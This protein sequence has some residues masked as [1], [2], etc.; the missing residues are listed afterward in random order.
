MVVTLSAPDSQP[1]KNS[2][3]RCNA[4]KNTVDPKLF[5]IDS[6]LLIDLG[7]AVEAGGNLLLFGSSRQKISRQLLNGKLI[8]GHVAIECVDHPIGLLPNLTR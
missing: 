5:N 3:G 8:E 1:K 7:V 6:S 2:T 4:I